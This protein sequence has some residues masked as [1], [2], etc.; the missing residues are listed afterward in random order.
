[1][2]REEENV[3]H[4]MHR[5]LGALDKN[6]ASWKII[7]PIMKDDPTI[8]IVKRYP[9]VI[10]DRH[11]ELG[12]AFAIGM[13]HALDYPGPVLTMVSDLSNPPEEM[14]LL[15]Q[16][17]G[18]V[19]IGARGPEIPRRLLSRFVNSILQGPCTDYT[20]AYRLY[21]RPV[22]EKVLP[23]MRSKGFAFLP[24]FIFRALKA[25]FRVSEVMVSHPPRTSGYSKLSYRSN[26]H[27][28]LRLVAW[29]YLS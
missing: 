25:G 20:N 22:L 17:E 8:D 23:R 12:S 21:R 6:A 5:L 7:A 3:D 13:R 24:E 28:Y 2:L 15:L 9:V 18:D 1:M 29:R 26:L 11:I 27:E 16:A 14:D 19:I 10:V 4:F